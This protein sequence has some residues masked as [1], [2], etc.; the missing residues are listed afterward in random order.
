VEPKPKP[1]TDE[2]DAL[3]GHIEEHRE[4]LGQNLQELRQQLGG[5]IQQAQGRVEGAGERVQERVQHTAERVHDKVQDAKDRVE[6]VRGQVRE[7]S[8]W[9][10]WLRKQPLLLAALAFTG[11]FWLALRARR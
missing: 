8:D 4:R 10:V 2:P 9:R 5:A 1:V 7:A 3:V 11:G 6:H